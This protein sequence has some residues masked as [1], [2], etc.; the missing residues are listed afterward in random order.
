MRIWFSSIASTIS[1]I[2]MARLRSYQI[3][4][5]WYRNAIQIKNTVEQNPP[6]T[7]FDPYAGAIIVQ[8]LQSRP[9]RSICGLRKLPGSAVLSH[10]S[11]QASEISH[12]PTPYKV[13]GKCDNKI[14]QKTQQNEMEHMVYMVECSIHKE[15]QLISYHAQYGLYE[16]C[17]RLKIW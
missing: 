5:S 13:Y 14:Q 1:E 11:G 12:T 16:T 4:A 2:S 3:A 7:Y 8:S 9:Q 10:Q 15:F 6:P 17:A